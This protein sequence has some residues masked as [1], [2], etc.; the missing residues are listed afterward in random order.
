M[1]E[2]HSEFFTGD[3]GY[4]IF[5]FLSVV[6]SGRVNSKQIEE[7]KYGCRVVR[8]HALRKFFENLDVEMALSD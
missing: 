5:T 2:A 6:F 4:Q 3:G 8:G 7:Q 1:S